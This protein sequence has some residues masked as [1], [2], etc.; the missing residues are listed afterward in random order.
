MES[1]QGAPL[2]IPFSSPVVVDTIERQV[3]YYNSAVR[4][5]FR[6]PLDGSPTVGPVDVSQC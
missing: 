1:G 4:T 2:S 3:Y 5:L 6:S